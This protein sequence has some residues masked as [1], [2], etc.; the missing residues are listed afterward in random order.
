MI[1]RAGVS[2]ISSTSTAPSNNGMQ[3][4]AIQRIFYHQS[5]FA[6]GDAGRYVASLLMKAIAA[7]QYLTYLAL[8][9][10]YFAHSAWAAEGNG[11]SV[12]R[13]SVLF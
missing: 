2:L 3:R 5:F 11:V 1:T 10:V 9:V 13:L 12:Y 4:S 6:P 7:I 8:G